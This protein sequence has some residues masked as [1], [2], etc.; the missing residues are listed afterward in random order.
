MKLGEWQQ[1]A[2]IHVRNT[3]RCYAKHL[4]RVSL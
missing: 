3:V 4:P 1:S 2:E